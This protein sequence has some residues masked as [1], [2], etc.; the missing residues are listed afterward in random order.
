MTVIVNLYFLSSNSLS[1]HTFCLKQLYWQ[2]S[3]SM[4]SAVLL[5]AV[6]VEARQSVG[7]RV[8]WQLGDLRC[9]VDV[10]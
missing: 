8:A 4:S 7:Q 10:A 3:L 6:V 2:M 9:L 5:A 1:I